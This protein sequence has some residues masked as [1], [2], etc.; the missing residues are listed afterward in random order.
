MK[1]KQSPSGSPAGV[2]RSCA[3]LILPACRSEALLSSTSLSSPLASQPSSS[4]LLASEART[5]PRAEDLARSP[6]K[7]LSCA[8]ACA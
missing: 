6:A 1:S 4:S 2:P 3:K 5:R 7:D 8:V